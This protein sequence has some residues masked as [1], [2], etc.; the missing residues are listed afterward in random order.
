MMNIKTK[1]VIN[2]RSIPQFWVLGD[3]CEMRWEDN[4]QNMEGTK[5][6]YHCL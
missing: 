2:D 6:N 1:K 4:C 3:A 5:Q